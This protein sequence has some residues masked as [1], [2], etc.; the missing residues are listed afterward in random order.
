V[1][2]GSVILY[3]IDRETSRKYTI[4][5]FYF[6]KREARKREAIKKGSK[7]K[8]SKQKEKQEKGKQEKGKGS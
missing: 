6:I 1:L 2:N 4:F 5:Y 3:I 8:G 7:K